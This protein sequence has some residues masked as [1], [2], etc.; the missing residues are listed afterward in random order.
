MRRYLNKCHQ[1]EKKYAGTQ[2]FTIAYINK[3]NW[4]L[5]GREI[6]KKIS[7][8]YD[9]KKSQSL[10]EIQKLKPVKCYAMAIIFNASFF[11]REAAYLSSCG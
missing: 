3:Y 4:L 1:F 9:T 10:K 6:C 8:Y 5:D 7:V 11:Y 2:I